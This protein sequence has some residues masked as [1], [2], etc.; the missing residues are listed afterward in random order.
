MNDL[1][2]SIREILSAETESMKEREPEVANSS[3]STI[4]PSLQIAWD[5][6]SLGA[7]ETCPEFYNLSIR[8]GYTTHTENV[9]LTFGIL[10]HSVREM[11]DR[12][13]IG[14]V[15]WRYYRHLRRFGVGRSVARKA[16]RE[17]LGHRDATIC[18]L[19]FILCATWDFKRKRPWISD[20]PTKNRETL[21]RAT[22]WYLDQY[23]NDLLE[24]FVR[25]DGRP[26]VELSFRF[27]SGIKSELTG[28]SFILCGHLDRVALYQDKL[29]I[30]DVK[31]TKYNLDESFF[32]KYYIDDQMSL[33][34]LAGTLILHEPIRGVMI[35][36]WQTLANGN[37]FQRGE[38]T[39]TPAQIEE[40]LL[41]TAY[42]L[43]QAEQFARDNHWPK[44]PNSC[45]RYGRFCEFFEVCASDPALREH[46]LKTMFKK[47]TWDPMK[48]RE[49]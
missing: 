27:D 8:Q 26:A 2:L 43:R 31:T 15:D 18:V 5:S 36:G 24:T 40:W 28:E 33:Y 34:S 7:L 45:F 29:W 35:D 32:A 49:V 42:R 30:C 14:G 1:E 21:F 13:R 39:R 46:K 23:Q 10:V 48:T 25:K 16:C 44:R 3:F 47:R 20:E 11:Y 17:K 37:R 19:R 4:L 38:V 9:H 6:T 12:L 41:D 22:I